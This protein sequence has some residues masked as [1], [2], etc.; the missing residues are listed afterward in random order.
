MKTILLIEDNAEILDNTSEILQL[1]GYR[2][3]TAENGK[4]GVEAALASPPDLIICDVMMPVL[5]GYGVFHLVRKNADLAH[6]PFIFLTAKSERSDLRKGMELGADDYITKPYSDTE[7]LSAVESRLERMERLRKDILDQARGE[8]PEM[9]ELTAEAAIQTLLS[10]QPVNRYRKKQPI[11]SEG[12]RGQFL[13]YVKRG[14]AKVYK[15][16][17]DGKELTI[18]LYGAGDFLG[19]IAL[20]EDNRYEV[21]AEAMQET[22]VVLIPGNE[23]LELVRTNAR[24]ATMFF[25]LVARHNNEKAEQLVQVAY[26]SLRKRVANSLLVLAKK[27]RT[28]EAENFSIHISREELANLAGTATESLIR[29]LADFRHEKLI[30]IREGDIVILSEKGLEGMIN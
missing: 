24:V 25:R 5:D 7:L 14:R 13:F 6:I 10:G 19:Y 4:A 26:H 11:F 16:S 30:D 17:D 2:V 29:T 3:M 12:N 9:A 1:A 21:S 22:E 27:Y 8:A 20:L 15:S 28:G 23:F 18:G